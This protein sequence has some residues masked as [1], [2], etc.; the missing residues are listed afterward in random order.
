MLI[1]TLV[2]WFLA[3][4]TR[5]PWRYE[6][7]KSSEMHALKILKCI[8]HVFECSKFYQR[9]SHESPLFKFFCNKV[10]GQHTVLFHTE[11]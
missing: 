6:A 8:A 5:I 9:P 1:V 2:Q 7:P 11:I 10:G 4:C 3:G